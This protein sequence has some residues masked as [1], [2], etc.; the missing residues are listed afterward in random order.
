MPTPESK[1]EFFRERLFSAE[2]IR[3]RI[4]EIA[5]EIAQKYSG[6]R[7]LLV[8]VLKGGF[9]VTADLAREL[10]KAGLTDI[11]I[12]FV[13]LSSYGDAT[14]SNRSPHLLKDVDT[15]VLGRSVLLVEDIADT[16]YSLAF[17]QAMFQSRGVTSL[18]TFALLSKPSKHDVEFQIDYLG[19]TCDDWVEGF[20]IDTAQTGRGNP[21]IVR[22]VKAL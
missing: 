15:N 1:V 21:D 2:D 20:G 13:S 6:Q 18:E 12:D 17:L 22:V 10:H 9:M 16:G 11:E 8:G 4:H 14:E 3:N 7:L 19:F 5:L